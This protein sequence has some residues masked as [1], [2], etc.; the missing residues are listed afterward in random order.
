MALPTPGAN[1][2]AV[3]TGASSGIGREIARRLAARGHGLTLV[4][5]RQERLR[6]LADEVTSAHG[7]RTEIVAADLTDAAAREGVVAAV[8]AAGLVPAVLVN[9][10]GLSTVGPVHRNDPG[11]ELTMIRTDVEA[12][13]HLC[14]LVLPGMVERGAGA[15]L[16]VGST[17][18]FQPMPGQAGYAASKAFVVSYSQALRGELRGTG[19]TVTALCPGPVETEFA[20][21]AGFDPGDAESALPRF[22]WVAVEDVA[23]AAVEGLDKGRALVIPGAANRLGALGARLTPRSLLVPIIARQHPGL[24]D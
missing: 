9:A 13:A 23:D 16:N 18:A 20:E 7:V 8:D 4:A 15:V 2:T 11:A 17:A 24:R 22:M 21:S 1:T 19:V 12:V 6:A 5:R 10:A 3:V 14:S